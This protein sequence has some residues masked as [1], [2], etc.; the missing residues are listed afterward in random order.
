MGWKEWSYVKKGA[1]IGLIIGSLP[2]LATI[3]FGSFLGMLAGVPLMVFPT[4]WI[5]SGIMRFTKSRVIEDIIF[6]MGTIVVLGI[7]SYIGIGALVGKL[8]DKI[9][10]RQCIANKEV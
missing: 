10:Q 1:L 4:T 2:A 8:V 9:K 3:V 5:L 7:L 6:N